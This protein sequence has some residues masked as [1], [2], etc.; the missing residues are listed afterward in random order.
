[1]PDGVTAEQVGSTTLPDPNAAGGAGPEGRV[2]AEAGRVVHPDSAPKDDTASGAPG[3]APRGERAEAAEP[4]DDQWKSALPADDQKRVDR[5]ITKLRQGD[6][7]KLREL[8]GHVGRLQWAEDLNKLVA[9]ENPQDR[10]RAVALLEATVGTLKKYTPQDTPDP[11]AQVDW[12]SA[13]AIVPGIGKALQQQRAELQQLRQQLGETRTVSEAAARRTA[14]REFEAEATQ[15]EAWAK[16]RNLPFDLQRIIETEN[17]LD[18]ADLR[19]AYYAT[20]GDELITAGT[21]AA[22]S[23]LER[24]KSASLP[25]GSSG[26]GAPVRPKFTS[27]QQQWEWVKRERGITG[28]IEYKG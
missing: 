27:M 28:P 26:A 20:Y 19:A 9:S 17:K 25:G 7:E 2:L 13:E 24:K 22:Q 3:S 16:E 18:I 21:K 23:G 8:E 15:L 4:D 10:L 12:Q 14:Q 11:L 1:M 6:T 5:I